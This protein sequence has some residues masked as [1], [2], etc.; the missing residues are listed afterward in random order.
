VNKKKNGVGRRASWA[1][2]WRTAGRRGCDGR[3]MDGVESGQRERVAGRISAAA[4]FAAIGGGARR[5][6]SR[7]WR[8]TRRAKDRAR[9]AGRHLS[10]PHAHMA[11]R[12]ARAP[13]R[14]IAHRKYRVA[15]PSSA[16]RRGD[17]LRIYINRKKTNEKQHQVRRVW[18]N[19]RQYRQRGAA[20]ANET[21]CGTVQTVDDNRG[22]KRRVGVV[23]CGAVSVQTSARRA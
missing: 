5:A 10:Y 23:W 22:G 1:G 21:V 14:G 4:T 18:A 8:W 17:V 15:R 2:A 3:A 9:G 16:R 13:W 6:C 20:D 19:V 12:I 11:L 7:T